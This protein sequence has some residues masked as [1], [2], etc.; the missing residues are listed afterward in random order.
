[1]KY[2]RLVSHFKFV[3]MTSATSNHLEDPELKFGAPAN[4]QDSDS[5]PS[6]SFDSSASISWR[7]HIRRFWRF[8]GPTW[9]I[10]V[11]FVDP[12][13]IVG[14]HFSPYKHLQ[15]RCNCIHQADEKPQSAISTSHERLC[16]AYISLFA[17]S[18]IRT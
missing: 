8:V 9:L 3:Q 16:A 2:G 18:N 11:T 13:G 1:M 14:M 6:P 12:G 7:G 4:F 17:A 15:V 10:A 5:L